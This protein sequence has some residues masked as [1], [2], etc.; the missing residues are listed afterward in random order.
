MLRLKNGCQT[1]ITLKDKKVQ[2]LWFYV[3]Y[4]NYGQIYNLQNTKACSACKM[5]HRVALLTVNTPNQ[6]HPTPNI[7]FDLKIFQTNYLFWPK[8][9]KFYPDLTSF[10]HKID[11]GSTKSG[12]QTEIFSLHVFWIIKGKLEFGY[13]LLSLFLLIFWMNWVIVSTFSPFFQ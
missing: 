12:T 7:F 2:N 4:A 3:C 1:W 6:P 13:A 10:E 5:G 11:F 8:Q 9:T